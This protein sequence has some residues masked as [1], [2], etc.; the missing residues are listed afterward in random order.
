MTNVTTRKWNVNDKSS[1]PAAWPQ[2]SPRTEN[3]ACLTKFINLLFID[4]RVS[5][6]FHIILN[7]HLYWNI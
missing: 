4:W 6:S 2:P 3:A 7:F 1:P 5:L